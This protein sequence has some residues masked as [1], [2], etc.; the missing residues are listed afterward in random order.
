MPTPYASRSCDSRGCRR[1][2]VRPDRCS[3]GQSRLAGLPKWWPIAADIR[4]GLMP[5]SSTRSPGATRSGMAR[6]YAARHSARVGRV[7][8]ATPTIVPD[9]SGRPEDVVRPDAAPEDVRVAVGRVVR[10]LP[11]RPPVGRE[12]HLPDVRGAL[13]PLHPQPR[14]ERPARLDGGHEPLAYGALEP[15]LV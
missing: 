6:P 1:R 12:R 4:P 7:H 9:R 10:V 14:P 8:V 3:A 13:D 15:R 11:R 5:T 2:G